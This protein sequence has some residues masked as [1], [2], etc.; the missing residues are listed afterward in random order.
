[1]WTQAVSNGDRAHRGMEWGARGGCVG[2]LV[3]AGFQLAHADSG[4]KRVFLSN[5]ETDA[6]ALP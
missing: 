5:G 6:K 3:A 2:T 4:D 1:M